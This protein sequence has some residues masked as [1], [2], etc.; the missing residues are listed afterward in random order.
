MTRPNTTAASAKRSSEAPTSSSKIPT[1][2]S[3]KLTRLYYR[4]PPKFSQKFF[5]RS[6][7]EAIGGSSPTG[8]L[9]S[10]TETPP[11]Y[12]SDTPGGCFIKKIFWGARA[13]PTPYPRCSVGGR[14]GGP[15]SPPLL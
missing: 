14:R 5:F 15:P 13:R 11:S 4:T 8:K 7:L 2:V 6:V 12:V 10:P 9:S 1:T 3:R